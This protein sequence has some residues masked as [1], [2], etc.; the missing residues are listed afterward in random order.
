M[1]VKPAL[2]R[3]AHTSA[4]LA[5]LCILSTSTAVM[6]ASVTLRWD[7]SGPATDGYRL[8]ARKSGQAYNYSQPDWEGAGVTGTLNLLD[9]QTDYYIVVRAYKDNIESANSNEVHYIPPAAHNDDDGMPDDWEA[10]FGLD[11]RVDDADSDLDHDGISNRDEFRAGLEPYDPG[12]GKS[13]LAPEL[14]FP[15]SDAKV[16]RNPLLDVGDFSDVDGDAHIATQWQVYR[17]GSTNCLLDVVTHRWL[18]LLRV[19]LLLLNGDGT[20]SW[21]VRFFDSGGRASAWSARAYFTT[22]AAEG[23]LDN[24]GISDN[25]EGGVVQAQV[26]RALSSPTITCEPTD[27]VVETAETVAEIKQMALLDPID[28]EIDETTPD[29]LPS[30]MLAYKLVLH[31]PGQRALVTIKLSDP[32]PAGAT[33]IKYDAVNGWQDYSHHAAI[34]ADRQS[35]TVEV[36]DGG[37]GDADGVANGIIVDPAGLSI[38]PIAPTAGGGSG[39]RCFISTIHDVKNELPSGSGFWQSIKDSLIRLM[40]VAST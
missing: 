32:A 19:P 7:P 34:S 27:L 5:F 28:L 6:A 17:N 30:A 11:P 14:L 3:I 4:I 36:T 10:R 20:Y 35:V 29:R 12:V 8:F 13:P 1:N 40:E 31:R 39:G 21:R 33:W 24:N 26:T 9:G 22:Q 23:D 16:E 25:Q 37:Y 18:N 2:Y 15:V 38:A